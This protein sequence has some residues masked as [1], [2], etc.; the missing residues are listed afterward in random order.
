[1]IFSPDDLKDIPVAHET[2]SQT[3][4][5]P[6]FNP[7][8]LLLPMLPM[9]VDGVKGANE[10]RRYPAFREAASVMSEIHSAMNSPGFREHH[11]HLA[12][13]FVDMAVLVHHNMILDLEARQPEDTE[14]EAPEGA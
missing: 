11:E 9:I 5:S 6:G 1:M 4:P 12:K 8:S 7:M 3:A 10:A 14:D 2:A 13:L